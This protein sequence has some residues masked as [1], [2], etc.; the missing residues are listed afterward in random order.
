[1]VQALEW[2]LPKANKSEESIIVML[3]SYT[4]HTTK[5]VAEV[6]REKGHF[7]IFHGGGCTPVIQC[8]DTVHTE[9]YRRLVQ[10]TIL[11][12]R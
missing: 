3:D 7:L 9:L 11:G 10:R 8:N 4:G 1:M 5:E 6:I 2:M 12:P